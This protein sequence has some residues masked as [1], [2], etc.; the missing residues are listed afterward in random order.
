MYV[1]AQY[2]ARQTAWVEAVIDEFPL[3]V[4]MTLG[5]REPEAS[6]LPVIRSGTTAPDAP[7]GTP[8]GMIL[9]G[10]MNRANPHWESL[11]P[12][13]RAKLAFVGP[14]SYITPCVYGANPSAP[15]WNFLS[16]HVSGVLRPVSDHAE[17]MAIIERT[18]DTFEERFGEGWDREPSRDYF[19]Q[20]SPAVGAFEVVVD[21]ITAMV[22]LSQEKRESTRHLVAEYLSTHTRGTARDLGRWMSEYFRSNDAHR[23][24]GEA[25]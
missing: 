19:R 18:V 5:P 17:T 6:H 2:R 24:S 23:E 16:V 11:V 4:F 1:P 3:A 8:N 13:Q 21:S 9:H 10:H 20:I 15:T 12:G 25:E 14:G 7:A 22:K